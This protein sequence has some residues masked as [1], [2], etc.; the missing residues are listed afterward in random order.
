MGPICFG[1][2]F[3]GKTLFNIARQQT[4][5]YFQRTFHSDS[6]PSLPQNHLTH[7]PS[8][9][10]FASSL[11]SCAAEI[12]LRRGWAQKIEVNSGKKLPKKLKLKTK[13]QNSSFNSMT[14]N[15]IKKKLPKKTKP[16]NQASK[17]NLKTKP[18]KE[19]HINTSMNE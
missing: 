12:L 17:P 15:R 4:N 13:S 14:L 18:K 11:C 8:P 9:D 16:Q 2:T 3:Y 1:L 19:Y 7:L 6:L 5:H 10:C